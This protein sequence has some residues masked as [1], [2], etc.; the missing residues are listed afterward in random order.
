MS[1]YICKEN[2][3]LLWNFM[4]NN[5]KIQNSGLK[6]LNYQQKVDLFKNTI[7]NIYI[8]LT[9]QDLTVSDLNSLNRKTIMSLI[10]GVGELAFQKQKNNENIAI[11]TPPIVE[12]NRKERYINEFEERQKMYHSMI[13]KKAPENIDFTEKSDFEEQNNDMDELLKKHVK[14]REQDYQVYEN[15][16][17]N[18][19]SNNIEILKI[20]N[21]SNISIQPDIINDKL[22]PKD[23]KKSVS[24]S[25]DIESENV[26]YDKFEKLE[27]KCNFI[28]ENL[29]KIINEYNNLNDKYE[30][31]QKR[32]KR[33]NSL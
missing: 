26:I 15:T 27:K 4:N 29:G 18:A 30:T 31:L 6:T 19:T 22:I 24:W 10:N 12:N 23:N 7:H 33:S 11:N 3:E 32:Y 25:S 2:Q 17:K 13:E 9:T 16:K 1:L 21:S 14:E 28:F 20:D 5:S 8:Q